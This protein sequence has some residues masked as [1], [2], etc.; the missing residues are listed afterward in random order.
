[1]P[2]SP[3]SKRRQLLAVSLPRQVNKANAGYYYLFFM[4]GEL[5]KKVILALGAAAK[6]SFRDIKPW[7]LANR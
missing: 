5:G 7:F 6:C 3:A 2:L 4:V 1:M